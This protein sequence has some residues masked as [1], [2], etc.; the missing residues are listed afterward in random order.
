M[1]PDFARR[2]AERLGLPFHPAVQKLNER[3]EQRTMQNSY[4]QAANVLDA[5][6]L[7]TKIPTGPVLLVDDMVESGW[8]LT[9]VGAVLHKA[10][11][12]MVYPF[13]LAQGT[14]RG[15]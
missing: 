2:L 5:F 15:T 11:C 4:Q 1:L 6:S 13:A 10:G 3:P 12:N 9:V 14:A 8:T 7:A